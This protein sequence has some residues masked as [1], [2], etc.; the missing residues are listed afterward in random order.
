MLAKE[1]SEFPNQKSENLDN[2]IWDLVLRINVEPYKEAF[3]KKSKDEAEQAKIQEAKKKLAAFAKKTAEKFGKFRSMFYSS[4]MEKM[5]FEVKSGKKPTKMTIN[6]NEKN[7]VHI[8]PQKDR[9]LLIYGINFEQK[10]DVALVKVL[11]QELQESQR[12]VNG[13]VGVDHYDEVKEIPDYVINV[14]KAKNFSNGLIVFHL[15]PEK[16]DKLRSKFHT[17]VFLKDY[18][19]FHVHSIK[20]FLHI[21]MTKKAKYLEDKLNACKIIPDDYYKK[22]KDINFFL[23]MDKKNEKKAIFDSEVKKIK[24]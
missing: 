7:K 16:L 24:V 20:T 18:L 10:T 1:F 14:E 15:K 11:L 19:Q 12:H 5:L 4:V 13:C 23:N 9:V 8:V 3:S 22:M 2:E 17:F 6:L 21:R